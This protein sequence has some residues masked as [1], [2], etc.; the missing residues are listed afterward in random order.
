VLGRDQDI[1]HARVDGNVLHL[2]NPRHGLTALFTAQG[3]EVQSRGAGLR[4]HF[5]GVGRG[6]QREATLPDRPEA[7]ANRVE[8][9]RGGLTEWYVNGP[10]GLEQGFTLTESPGRAT[11]EALT[12]ALYLGGELRPEPASG[13]MEFVRGDGTVVLRYRGLAAWDATG[14]ELPA[15]WQSAGREV[16]LRVDDS[17]ARYPVTIDPLIEE[18]KLTASDGAAGDFFGFSVAV[19]GDTVVVCALLKD[20]DGRSGKGA[21]YVFL[22]QAGGFAG[23]LQENA[24]LTASDDAGSTLFFGDSVAVSGDTI[25][26]GNFVSVYVFMKPAGG[27]AGQLTEDAKLI[28]SDGGTF[29]NSVAVSGDTVVVGDIGNNS[30]QGAAFVFV[31]PPAGW[32]GTLRENAVLT[33]SDGAADDFFGFSVA[34]SHDTVV[35]GAPTLSPSDANRGAAYVFVEPAG[36]WVGP[37][38]E[39]A[40]LTHS[41]ANAMVFGFSVD[42]S[43]DTVVATFPAA[44]FVKPVG[45]WAGVLTESAKLNLGSSRVAISGDTVASDV[46][47]Q[48]YRKPSGGWA[49]TVTAAATFTASD[50]GASGGLGLSVALSG[51]TLV[52]GAPGDDIGGRADQGSAYVF[53]ASRGEAEP[54]ARADCETT[55][56]G[57][58][59]TC[60]LPPAQGIGCATRVKLLVRA[61]AAR[62]SDGVPAKAKRLIRFAAGATN[63]PPGRNKIVRL[64]LT[65]KGREIVSKTRKKTLRAVAE[66][67]NSI[68]T[69]FT[70]PITI[71]LR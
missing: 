70:S 5:G 38:T 30:R 8:Y 44:V 71:R 67:R 14:R 56:C 23:A 37:L 58:R 18:A 52:A 29:A 28:P 51:N 2:D 4:L 47:L 62:L 15:W 65:K 3:V 26:V 45:G 68:G 59:V 22:K 46:P 69:T 20:I 42:V 24:R 6:A 33:A 11:G 60:N 21:A 27:W 36:G 16:R 63:V 39:N 54:A 53:D 43:G 57:L 55:G 1:Y 35:I 50:S 34:V 13:G 32:F 48:V 17:G 49:G 10:L 41:D 25:V 66:I 40:K 12:L 64:K 31:K 61:N 9:R 7:V 19:D